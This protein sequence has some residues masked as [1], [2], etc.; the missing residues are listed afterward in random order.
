MK[1]RPIRTTTIATIMLSMLMLN[2]VAAATYDLSDYPTMFIKDGNFDSYIVVGDKAPAIDVVSATMI[3]L[4]LQL[5]LNKMD[6]DE[7]KESNVRL[8]SEISDVYEK[9]LIS[10]G[11]VCDND[12]TLK[13]LQDAA[14][15]QVDPN[16]FSRRVFD[17]QNC[18]PFDLKPGQ[19]IIKYLN[20]NGKHQLI[21][22]GYAPTD[23]RKAAEVLNR[24]D[25]FG[26]LLQ[27][28]EAIVSGTNVDLRLPPKVVV[29]VNTPQ[30]PNVNHYSPLENVTLPRPHVIVSEPGV[31]SEPV[32]DEP[33]HSYLPTGPVTDEPGHASVP[34][35]PVT[36]E[37]GYGVLT[38][39]VTDEPGH[40]LVSTQ[41]PRINPPVLIPRPNPIPQPPDPESIRTFTLPDPARFQ[42]VIS[43]GNGLVVMR[44]PA[45]TLP[46]VSAVKSA[47]SAPAVRQFV[48]RK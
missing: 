20:I 31:P 1:V 45:R 10:V 47:V 30:R 39:P 32:T 14:L 34:T 42:G 12:V 16:A 6:G 36:D 35:Q 3:A 48:L 28:Y 9:S 21:V 7:I 38:Q 27:G 26:R 25:Q 33:G 22:S 4:R 5:E 40:G 13:L 17:V 24:F 29:T 43:Q 2:V 46:A 37:P 11:L 23:T 44:V 8:A 18:N 41:I 19:G 15:D